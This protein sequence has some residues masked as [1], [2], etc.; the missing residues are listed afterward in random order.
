MILEVLGGFHRVL[1]RFFG[2]FS[3]SVEVSTRLSE[4]QKYPTYVYSTIVRGFDDNPRL[5]Y[6]LLVAYK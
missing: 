2:V 4:A 5:I 1:D 3:G 6:Q